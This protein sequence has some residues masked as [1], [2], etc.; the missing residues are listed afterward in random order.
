MAAGA[1]SDPYV[2]AR[3]FYVVRDREYPRECAD[4]YGALPDNAVVYEEGLPKSE[5]AREPLYVLGDE[6]AELPAEPEP[7]AAPPVE[8]TDDEPVAAEDLR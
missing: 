5:H 6:G 2:P 7:V 4:A 1:A 3:D 8:T